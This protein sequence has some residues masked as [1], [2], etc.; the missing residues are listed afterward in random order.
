MK[1]LLCLIL[2]ISMLTALLTPLTL[3]PVGAEESAPET[4]PSSAHP[5]Q[6]K[7][8]ETYVITRSGAHSIG[9]LFSEQTSFESDYD[10][11]TLYDKH[12]RFLSKYT[13]DQLSGA[14]IVINYDTVKLVLETDEQWTEYGFDVVEVVAFYSAFS[15]CAHENTRTEN[16]R[17]ASCKSQG[18]TGDVFCT[19]CGKCLE[20]GTKTPAEKKGH[21]FKNGFC[22]ICDKEEDLIRTSLSYAGYTANTKKTF[23]ISRPGALAIIFTFTDDKDFP[24]GSK[25]TISAL[26]DS[27]TFS[28]DEVEGE[29][30]TAFGSSF[31]ITYYCKTYNP[32]KD[33]FW[34]D[35]IMGLYDDDGLYYT[36]SDGFAQIAACDE[37]IKGDVLIPDTFMGY[38]VN[39]V[40]E[41]AFAGNT[42]LTGIGI[43]E[44]V[45][46]IREKAFYGCSS[47]NKAAIP[48][49]VTSIYTDAFYGANNNLVIYA[50]SGSRGEDYAA[51]L[52]CRVAP[53]SEA[54]KIKTQPKTAVAES[55]VKAQVS[56]KA[57]GYGL[58][59]QWYYKDRDAADFELTASFRGNAYAVSMNEA[60]D[61]R[62]LYCVVSDIYGNSVT[63]KTV[64]IHMGTPLKVLT[65]PKSVTVAYGKTAKIVL[66]VQG[67]DLTYNWYY[68]NKG[69]SKFSY[70]SSFKG[71][72][73]SVTMNSSR[74]GR[75]VYCRVTD[76]FGNV[77]A[78][79]VVTLSMKVRIAT[80]PKSVSA[81]KNKTAKTTVKAQGEGLK[82]TWYYKDKGMSKF[83][84]TTAFKGSS[85]YIS[86]TAARNGRQVY[87]KISDKFGNT[88]Q[89][90]TV[91]LKMK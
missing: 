66:D 46:A 15:S 16:V 34:L 51:D 90:K 31:T 87:C 25:F 33:D 7:T 47:L 89:T 81:A 14:F 77:L 79:K 24:S 52:G 83:T 67:E 36:V 74:S 69:D 19:E 58:T 42:S 11:L 55:G 2:T 75:Q 20:A 28:A 57:E 43:P 40:S 26:G 65:Q 10:Y 62:E 71:D 73:Y 17:E 32:Q 80:Q 1:K 63:T 64:S 78:T 86:M 82:Y 12:D 21:D 22:T 59:Y 37:R 72:T 39:A 50:E 53:L 60:R 88:V 44:S 91:T 68:K 6:N 61:G 54:L 84:K 30:F 56:V 45:V 23:T 29:T 5:Y 13:A 4:L 85:Y 18:N 38:P 27:V 9:L 76:K 49:S 8:K 3:L 35:S 48:P 70:T 41:L